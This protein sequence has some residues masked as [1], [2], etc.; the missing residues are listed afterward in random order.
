MLNAHKETEKDSDG[1][2]ESGPREFSEYK[3]RGICNLI[4]H[5]F[6]FFVPVF[7]R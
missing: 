4:S 3:N 5:G 6:Y 2:N 1:K 7:K